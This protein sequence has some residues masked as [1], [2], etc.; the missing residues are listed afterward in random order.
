[1]NKILILLAC[2][3]VIP[4]CSSINA[5][6]QDGFEGNTTTVQINIAGMTCTGCEETIKNGVTSLDGVQDA[7]AD[8]IQGQAWVTYDDA[9]VSEK[10]LAEAIEQRGYQVLGFESYMQ[11]TTMIEPK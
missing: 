5:D 1:M 11:D 8:Y 3:T 6:N 4:A 7:T 2:L 9:R 10:Q